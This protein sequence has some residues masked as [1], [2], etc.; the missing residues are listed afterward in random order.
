MPLP[1][2]PTKASNWE[3]L[4]VEGGQSSNL[5]TYCSSKS[6]GWPFLGFEGCVEPRTE[7]AARALCVPLAVRGPW[8]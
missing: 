3:R 8:F 1:P 2:K 6:S 7:R 5:V 4:D